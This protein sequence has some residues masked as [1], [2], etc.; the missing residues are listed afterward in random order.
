MNWY[1][2]AKFLGRFGDER[3]AWHG[4]GK[5]DRTIEEWQEELPEIKEE[6]KFY[7][8]KAVRDDLIPGI[9]GFISCML[10]DECD[11]ADQRKEHEKMIDL[12]IEKQIEIYEK[13]FSY[14]EEE[15]TNRE[16]KR[17]LKFI[18][19]YI[20]T[21]LGTDLNVYI[22]KEKNRNK[23]KVVKCSEKKN[24][25]VG[26]KVHKKNQKDCFL[27]THNMAHLKLN[28]NQWLELGKKLGYLK[29]STN[30]SS[31]INK[32][33]ND[34]YNNEEIEQSIEPI[35]DELRAL[36]E[37]NDRIAAAAARLESIEYEPL[38]ETSGE[39]SP[40]IEE[41]LRQL[42]SSEWE[43]SPEIEERLS[44][45]SHTKESPEEKK[46]QK[47]NAQ[48][49]AEKAR[50]IDSLDQLKEKIKQLE[51]KALRLKKEHEVAG[52]PTTQ[53]II[54]KEIEQVFRDIDRMQSQENIIMR[55]LKNIAIV[56]K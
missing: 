17:M 48:L 28:T 5:R 7:T 2:E 27:E 29:E 52:S 25:R 11:W 15:S 50:L 40:E 49:A 19:R 43:L 34:T 56:Q 26:L 42:R 41:R 32:S 51:R 35:E 31:S 13:H 4:I 16:K 9:S 18:K 12:L 46:K 39:L 6:I 23:K 1:K 30:M 54:V 37:E 22:N 10:N 55:G 14:L 53:R 47:Q 20:I 8:K 3:R 45:L 21:E 36:R 44:K 33:E 24:L 38:S